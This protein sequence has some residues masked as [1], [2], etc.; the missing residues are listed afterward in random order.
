MR[1]HKKVHD[2][3]SKKFHCDLCEMSFRR[4]FHL[5]EHR[6]THLSEEERKLHRCK[7]CTDAFSRPQSL[8][9]HVDACHSRL[10]HP[11]SCDVCG[12]RFRLYQFVLVSNLSFFIKQ[13]SGRLN[14]EGPPH[15][16]QLHRTCRLLKI[17]TLIC[18]WVCIPKKTM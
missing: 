13:V 11:F 16:L 3:K 8:K 4:Q 15:A 2:P 7:L 18:T 5:K 6:K 14:A 12:R 9:R 1:E 17:H 10:P